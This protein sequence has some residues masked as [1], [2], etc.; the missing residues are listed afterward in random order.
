MKK[1]LHPQTQRVV[2]QDM[3]T[4]TK[5]LVDSTVASGETVLW[6]DGKTYPL[7][8]VEISSSSHPIFTGKEAPESK[9]SRREQF[10]SKFARREDIH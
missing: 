10:E 2:F 6:E 4:G 7:V 5:F 8:K 9:T 1:N 3:V